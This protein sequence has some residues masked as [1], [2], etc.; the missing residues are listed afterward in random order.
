MRPGTFCGV[1]RNNAGEDGRVD[2]GGRDDV[3]EAREVGV[4]RGEVDRVEG[5]DQGE[6]A[7]EDDGEGGGSGGMGDVRLDFPV[8]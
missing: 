3:E 4:D 1:D 6:D 8:Y 7:R 5:S 2:D